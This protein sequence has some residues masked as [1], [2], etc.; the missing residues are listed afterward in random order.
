MRLEHLLS[1]AKDRTGI[2]DRHARSDTVPAIDD[3]T[4]GSAVVEATANDR[5]ELF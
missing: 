2:T 4:V 1:G 5:A 3:V